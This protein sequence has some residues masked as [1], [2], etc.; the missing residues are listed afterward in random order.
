MACTAFSTKQKSRLVW[1]SPLITTSSPLIIA[2]VHFGIT[3][4]YAPSGSWRLPNTLK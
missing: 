4:A 2:A 1:P 3:A